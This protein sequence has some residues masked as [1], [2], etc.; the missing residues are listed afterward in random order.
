MQAKQKS[1]P[2]SPEHTEQ[3]LTLLADQ[4]TEHAIFLLNLEKR[5][6]WWSRG[7]ER[8]FGIPREKAIGLSFKQ[9]F[10]PEDLQAGISDLELNV[11]DS[12]AMSEEDRWHVRA[13]GSTFRS[14]GA[15]IAI[16]NSVGNVVAFGKL[17]RDR[18][19]LK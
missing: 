5:V 1:Q 8:L 9:I 13:D 16:R 12:D 4:A 15:L 7:A 18:T 2:E 10:T 19:D 6:T 14:S 11:A 17:I 3:L